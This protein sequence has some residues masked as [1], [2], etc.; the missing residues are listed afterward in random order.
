[1]IHLLEIP[2]DGIQINRTEVYRYLGY[3]RIP[4]DE[5]ITAMTETL[6][7]EIQKVLTC[8]CV[9]TRLTVEIKENEIRLPG[10]T[11]QSGHLAK[12]LAGCGEV[13]L[14]AATI[15]VAFDRFLTRCQARSAA[16]ALI[17]D[18]IGSAAIEALSD[19]VNERFDS[20]AEK[21][22]RFLRPRFSPG[23]GD[24]PLSVQPILLNLLQASKRIGITLT[25]SGMMVPA[26]SVSALI[27]IGDMPLN[28][29]I[30]KC[31]GCTKYDCSYRS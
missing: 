13:Y 23:Y 21:Q 18:C 10:L 26:K 7:G 2:A 30:Q 31:I 29:E 16:S 3:K 1:M 24:F 28:C 6:I 22:G 8:R 5:Q 9:Y 4:E 12:N 14:F 20:E 27:G 17:A 11:V 15:G 25:D 19:A